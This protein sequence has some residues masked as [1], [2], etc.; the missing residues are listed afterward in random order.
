ME[1]TKT[2]LKISEKKSIMKDY[3]IE[4]GKLIYDNYKKGEQQSGQV[5]ELCQKLK[6][7]EAEI[8]ALQEQ[9]NNEE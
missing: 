8:K 5:S 3:Y 9:L 1:N 7:Q 6:E 2:T 4:I